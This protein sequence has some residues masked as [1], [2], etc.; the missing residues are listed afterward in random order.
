MTPQKSKETLLHKSGV[1]VWPT[2]LTNLYPSPVAP[3]EGYVR[4]PVVKMTHF[5]LNS[6]NSVRT[7]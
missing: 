7:P 3:V 2:F 5:A 6:S 1:I 4:P